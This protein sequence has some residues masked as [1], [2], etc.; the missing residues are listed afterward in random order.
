MI[1][2]LILML[3]VLVLIDAFI[4]IIKLLNDHPE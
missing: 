3:S 1:L 2:V 4:N